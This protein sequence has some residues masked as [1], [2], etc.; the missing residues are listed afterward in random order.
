MC[1][2]TFGEMSDAL[3]VG[4]G[5]GNLLTFA[6]DFGPDSEADLE[7]QGPGA[8]SVAAPAVSGAGD[9]MDEDLAALGGDAATETVPEASAVATAVAPAL[10]LGPR[11]QLCLGTKAVF[12]VPFRG[13]RSEP[14]FGG[15]S[16][17]KAVFAAC[18]RP[19]V[20]YGGAGGRVL[21]SSVNSSAEVAHAAPFNVRPFPNS[22]AFALA[23]SAAAGSRGRGAASGGGHSGGAEDGPRNEDSG[24][25][26]ELLIGCLDS[27]QRLHVRTV[28]LQGATPR[29]AAHLAAT[30][31]LA[32]AVVEPLAPGAYLEASAVRFFD[33]ASFAE[34]AAFPLEPTEEVL[35]LAA[36]DLTPL[37]GPGGA[38]AGAASGEVLVVGTAF[39]AE[40]GD[41]E[42]SK[43]RILVLQLVSNDH[44]DAGGMGS[45]GGFS[46]PGRGQGAS[47]AGSPVE[48]PGAGAAD[49]RRVEIVL[50]REVK[51]AVY[52]LASLDLTAVQAPGSPSDEDGG[53]TGGGQLSSSSGA[54]VASK[55]SGMFLACGVGAK[56]QMFRWAPRPGILAGLG[57]RPLFGASLDDVSGAASGLSGRW[58][59]EN[60][61]V[62]HGH[63]VALHVKC[64]V[65]S[66]MHLVLFFIF[67][68]GGGDGGLLLLLL[69]RLVVALF[70]PRLDPGARPLLPSVTS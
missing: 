39:G 60:E 25:G 67:G 42:P 22:L 61:C 36:V 41:Y 23:P 1:L 40:D 54:G 27:I 7:A 70:W 11:K 64:K 26:G 68:G 48:S 49:R 37:L 28:G 65:R 31:A 18:D 58:S 29:R 44:A 13:A 69:R 53:P 14:G 59:L 33:A 10:S 9:S 21:F 32:V 43:G 24:G 66:G 46:S 63:V 4:L 35:S 34:L 62:H 50:E 16:F 15:V 2:A 56:V 17:S 38:P 3:L 47:L 45:P 6:L 20:I 57:Q 52:D 19:A 55:T 12:L 8:S 51:G 5:D 30:R